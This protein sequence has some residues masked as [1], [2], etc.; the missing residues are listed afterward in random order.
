MPRIDA[1]PT[2][3]TQ[4]LITAA[5]HVKVRLWFLPLGLGLLLLAAAASA[6]LFARTQ[7]ARLSAQAEA[8]LAATT[9]LDAQESALAT[10]ARLAGNQAAVASQAHARAV[11]RFEHDLGVLA[12]RAPFGLG[13]L[14]PVA[15]ARRTLA[16]QQRALEASAQGDD[17]VA[18]ARL[19]GSG[20]LA[21]RQAFGAALEGLRATTT[22]AL[23]AE[24]RTLELWHG[25][26][27]LGLVLGLALLGLGTWR[28][29]AML[30]GVRR[31]EEDLA[32]KAADLASFGTNMKLLHRLST[33]E[34][35]DLDELFRDY[36]LSGCQMLDVDLG[37]ISL[38]VDGVCVRRACEQRP[39]RASIDPGSSA[40]EAICTA[41]FR[42]GRTALFQ[43]GDDTA[44]SHPMA[45][46]LTAAGMRLHIGV[47]I[48]VGRSAFGVLSFAAQGA[49]GRPALTRRE[50]ELVELMARSLAAR[51][52]EGERQ[53]HS[54]RA[55]Q[56]LVEAREAAS[57]ASRLKSDF[58]AVMSHEI[59]TPLSA[60]IGMTELLQDTNLDER[61]RDYVETVRVSSEMLHGLINDVLDLSK[62]EAGHLELE[63]ADF[64]PRRV[65][66]EVLSVLRPR[67]RAKGLSLEAQVAADVPTRLHGDGGRFRQVLTN[68]VTNAVK[69]TDRGGVMARLARGDERAGRIELRGEVQD[70]GPGIASPDVARLFQPFSQL[71]ASPTRRHGGSGLGLAISRQLV[72]RMDGAIG[73]RSEPGQ[74]STFWFTTCFGPALYQ[75]V[76]E[77]APPPVT[78][79]GSADSG[80]RVLVAEDDVVN[81]RVVLAMLARLGYR[82][83]AVEDGRRA[84][85]AA[86]SGAYSVVLMD[87]SMPELDGLQATQEIRRL[88]VG[89]PRLPILALTANALESERRRCL[90]AGMDGYLSKPVR[91]EDL[92]EAL[93]RAL[94]GSAHEPDHTREAGVR[95]TTG[96]V[97]DV[98]YLKQLADPND[99]VFLLDLVHLVL[100]NTRERLTTLKAA[101]DVQD[102]KQVA[103]IAHALQGGTAHAGARSLSLLCAQLERQARVGEPL[104]TLRASLEQIES[105]FVVAQR[106]LHLFALDKPSQAKRTDALAQ[107][108]AGS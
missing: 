44:A 5:R 26:A 13:H 84:V 25:A 32:H 86:L 62:I 12:T 11:A 80:P 15:V 95:P 21:D 72:E 43:P 66:S 73:V 98:E 76:S 30:T 19:S 93:V 105:A 85:E 31:T 54:A 24:Q 78:P 104:D 82:A 17:G 16:V 49:G 58:L 37:A 50:I 75:P 18:L 45:A 96:P 4:V 6:H 102:V 74:G 88:G 10:W 94:A 79:R 47:P 100:K 7:Q 9:D 81:R 42:G 34:Y 52:A 51:L 27:G 77:T 63:Q 99:D 22:D 65:M 14:V 70:T 106:E 55:Q 92:H 64:D 89:R 46:Q 29:H 59:R 107:P 2:P 83:D 20:Y 101:L 41:V 48:A 3:A 97:L 35:A 69:F 23:R 68:L 8:C 57:E 91:S 60:V 28:V 40:M 103:S 108:A 38:H 71:D 33:S 90:A 87:C 1:T 53:E 39:G 61:Q 67:A 36:L 56:A